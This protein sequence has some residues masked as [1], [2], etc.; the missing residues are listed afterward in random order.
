MWPS[1]KLA[2][3][4]R[5]NIHVPVVDRPWTPPEPDPDYYE[6]PFASSASP[7]DDASAPSPPSPSAHPSASSW[8]P[9]ARPRPSRSHAYPDPSTA[10]ASSDMSSSSGAPVWDGYPEHHVHQ[11]PDTPESTRAT[12]S[13]PLPPSSPLFSTLDAYNEKPHQHDVL[14]YPITPESSRGTNSILLRSP[15]PLSSSHPETSKSH[16]PLHYPDTPESTRTAK[17]AQLRSLSP[18]RSMPWDSTS[19]PVQHALKSCISHLENLIQTRKPNDDQMEYLVSKFEDMTECLSAPE[20]QSRQ[21]DDYLFS[22]LEAPSGAAGLGILDGHGDHDNLGRKD[23][24]MG[25]GYVLAVGRYIEDVQAHIQDL[26]MRMD[27]V[28]QLNSIQLEI[29]DDLRRELREKSLQKNN[30]MR[31]SGKASKRLP[32]QGPGFWIAVGEALDA[33]G[34]LLFEW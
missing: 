28:K 26:Q 16:G 15:S 19:S 32:P 11:L 18:L 9:S 25:R 22:D 34:D 2:S 4:M 13:I 10:C 6:D 1:I 7:S 24:A 33:M 20:A 27:D 21:T 17:S 29:I 31:T 30:Q 12:H 5:P 8:P 3:S 14:Q 23:L